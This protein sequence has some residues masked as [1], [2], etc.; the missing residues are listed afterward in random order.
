MSGAIPQARVLGRIEK[1]ATPALTSLRFP[2]T[3]AM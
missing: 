3:D 2:S 1:K